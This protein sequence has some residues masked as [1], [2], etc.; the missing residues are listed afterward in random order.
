MSGSR[1]PKKRNHKFAAAV[2]TLITITSTACCDSVRGQDVKPPAIAPNA[3]LRTEEST[4]ESILRARTDFAV[5]HVPLVLAVKKLSEMHGIRIE[6][7]KQALAAAGVVLDAPV[8]TSIKS[9]T[10]RAAL[11]HLLGNADL[12][13]EVTDGV[14]AVTVAPPGAPQPEAIVHRRPAPVPRNVPFFKL[15]MVQFPNG[16]GAVA[17]LNGG[18]GIL[19]SPVHDQDDAE[20]RLEVD[21]EVPLPKMRVTIQGKG[22]GR[23]I[24]QLV[25]SSNE[26]AAAAHE[27][28]LKRLDQEIDAV[29]RTC[30]LTSGQKE[31]LRLA[32]R[33]DV[34]RLLDRA[35]EIGARF[36]SVGGIDDLDDFAKWAE[37]V[38]A[39]LGTIRPLLDSGPFDENSL[40]SK[41]LKRILTPEQAAKRSPAPQR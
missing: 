15:Q 21:G 10:L 25:F 40:F 33:G 24:E 19:C 7:D 1:A 37:I 2:V 8:T 34:K 31:K 41:T 36:E 32:G 3:Q 16:P 28:I 27:R 29:E 23:S 5:V 39:E 14:V 30:E 9:H 6:L 26:T 20:D 18:I 13:F 11:C 22:K 35:A 17:L 12:E 38:A 4:P